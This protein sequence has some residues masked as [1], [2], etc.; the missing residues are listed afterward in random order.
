MRNANFPSGAAAATARRP[1]GLR[2]SRRCRLQAFPQHTGGHALGRGLGDRFPVNAASDVG[3]RRQAPGARRVSA[4]ST[5]VRRPVRCRNTRSEALQI[6]RPVQPSARSTTAIRD[7]ASGEPRQTMRYR[8]TRR[9]SPAPSAPI[10]YRSPTQIGWSAVCRWMAAPDIPKIGEAGTRW[11]R[12]D[13]RG[14]SMAARRAG[15]GAGARRA[16]AAPAIRPLR[17]L[18]SPPRRDPG[19]STWQWAMAVIGKAFAIRACGLQN[20]QSQS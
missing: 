6:V 4:S 10:P 1:G 14:R 8:R 16:P 15:S 17:L 18:E 20:A 9:R 11:E 5:G 3:M 2:P 12:P 7:A 13:R 19:P